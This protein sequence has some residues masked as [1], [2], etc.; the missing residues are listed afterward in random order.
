MFVCSWLGCQ[1]FESHGSSLWLVDNS[2]IK[3]LDVLRHPD[4]TII[5]LIFN[6]NTKQNK[7]DTRRKLEC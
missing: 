4:S 7:C 6:E 1:H 2:E 3:L 5:F